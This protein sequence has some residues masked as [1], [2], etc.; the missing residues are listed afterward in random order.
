MKI[1]Y[2]EPEQTQATKFSITPHRQMKIWEAEDTRLYRQLILC[3]ELITFYNIDLYYL[4]EKLALKPIQ[5]KI[6]LQAYKGDKEKVEFDLYI[7]LTDNNGKHNIKGE[8][9]KSIKL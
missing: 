9:K 2:K 3:I 4:A 1:P 6:A 5:I 7:K 8:M